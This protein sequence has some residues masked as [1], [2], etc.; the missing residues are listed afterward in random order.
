[1]F[2]IYVQ[3]VNTKTDINAVSQRKRSAHISSPGRQHC[4]KNLQDKA[5]QLYRARVV[6]LAEIN[7]LVF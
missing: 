6:K 2:I 1:M 5:G 3:Q 7:V 4:K